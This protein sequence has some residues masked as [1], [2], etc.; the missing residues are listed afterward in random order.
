MKEGGNHWKGDKP[1][2]KNTTGS[3]IKDRKTGRKQDKGEPVEERIAIG[4]CSPK[5]CKP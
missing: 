5:S 1:K 3:N 4:V 2:E